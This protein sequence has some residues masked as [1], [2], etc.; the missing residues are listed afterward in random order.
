M[1]LS[2]GQVTYANMFNFVKYVPWY[3][4]EKNIEI[5]IFE[6]LLKV[7][8]ISHPTIGAPDY[9]V[10]SMCFVCMIVGVCPCVI[11]SCEQNISKTTGPVFTKLF[12]N[13]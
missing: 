12:Q 13:I 9:V 2:D 10:G 5:S 3:T 1:G 6:F 4:N 11:K 7:F 8:I